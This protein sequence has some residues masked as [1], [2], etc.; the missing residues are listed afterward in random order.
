MCRD[1]QSSYIPRQKVTYRDSKIFWNIFRY[2]E[3]ET[4][5]YKL[6]EYR[7]LTSCHYIF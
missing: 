3:S 5:F 1:L 4:A 2:Q 6:Q 7:I